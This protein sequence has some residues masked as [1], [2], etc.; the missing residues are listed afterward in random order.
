MLPNYKERGMEEGGVGGIV[1]DES[2]S[3]SLPEL[4]QDIRNNSMERKSQYSFSR[5]R[6]DI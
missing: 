2:T 6:A 5:N 3:G 1:L 4:F